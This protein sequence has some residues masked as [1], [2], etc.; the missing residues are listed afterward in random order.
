MCVC[1]SV[2]SHLTFG[3]LFRPE[4]AVTYSAGSEGQKICSVFS[5]TS[6]RERKLSFSLLYH[7]MGGHVLTESAHAQIILIARAKA[8]TFFSVCSGLQA[9]LSTK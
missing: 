6:V 7:S 5:K 3:A 2:K 4:N 9:R 1:V 8:A